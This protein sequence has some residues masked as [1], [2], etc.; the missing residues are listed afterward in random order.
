MP[1][2]LSIIELRFRD[3][4]SAKNWFCAT[5]SLKPHLEVPADGYCLFDL[6]GILLA[7]KQDEHAQPTE[8]VLLQWQVENVEN[9]LAE[10]TVTLLKPLKISH[11]GYRRVILS[12]P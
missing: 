1:A 5:F 4:N 10:H 9:W 6:H 7:I 8:Q 3:W 2:K 12:G 11:E